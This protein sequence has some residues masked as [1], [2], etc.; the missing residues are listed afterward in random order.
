MGGGS[1]KLRT[2]QSFGAPRFCILFAGKVTGLSNNLSDQ[3]SE[4]S[5]GPLKVTDPIF[6]NPPPEG[7]FNNANQS[8]VFCGF[9]AKICG[10]LRKSAFPKCFVF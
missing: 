3:K 7:L 8:A 1:P 9:T 10:F 6:V 4:V 5:N 2:M